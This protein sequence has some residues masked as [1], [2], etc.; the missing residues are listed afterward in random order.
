VYAPQSEKTGT[1]GFRVGLFVGFFVGFEVGC[2]VGFIVGFVVGFFVGFDVGF[3]VGVGIFVGFVVGLFVGTA[4]VGFDVGF[5]IG[6]AVGLAVGFEV[7][8]EVGTLVTQY[9]MDPSNVN[10]VENLAAM[11]RFPLV[12]GPAVLSTNPQ[13]SLNLMSVLFCWVLPDL[14]NIPVLVVGVRNSKLYCVPALS[15]WERVAG[16]GRT[17]DRPTPKPF[18]VESCSNVY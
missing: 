14:V 3:G 10:F 18:T 8:F 12:G 16:M 7:G 17:V 6:F 15:T 5:E 2:F 4:T 9:L 13:M 1:V 11:L